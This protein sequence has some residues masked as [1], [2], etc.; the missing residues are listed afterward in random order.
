MSRTRIIEADDLIAE[1][2]E[3]LRERG[4]R[5]DK[6]HLSG[7]GDTI[8]NQIRRLPDDRKM[9]DSNKSTNGR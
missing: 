3:W 1:L 6:P 8:Y 5:L 4:W 2:Q 9:T 7:S